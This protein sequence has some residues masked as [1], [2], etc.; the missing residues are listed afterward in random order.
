MEKRTLIQWDETGNIVEVLVGI[1]QWDGESNDEHIFF[2][3]ELADYQVGYRNDD[4]WTI[5]QIEKEESNMGKWHMTRPGIELND[6]QVVICLDYCDVRSDYRL[7]RI[8]F[9]ELYNG[10]I[11]PFY[12]VTD[13]EAVAYSVSAKELLSDSS[14]I[15]IAL[16]GTWG[17]TITWLPINL[18]K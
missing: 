7:A 8:Q 12:H 15:D 16:P 2:W 4:G 3:M 18:V 5:M 10:V 17:A 1:G 13:K 14:Y 9:V 6:E 11:E